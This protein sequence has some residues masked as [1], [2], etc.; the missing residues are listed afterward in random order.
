M[1]LLNANIC[2]TNSKRCYHQHQHTFT[3][4]GDASVVVFDDIEELSQ[5]GIGRGAAVDEEQLVMVEAGV[6]SKHTHTAFER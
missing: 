5:D 3:V 6:L 2:Y 4:Y 1:Y